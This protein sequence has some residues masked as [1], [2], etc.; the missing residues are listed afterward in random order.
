MPC[1][2]IFVEILVKYP[3]LKL[4]Q[5]GVKRYMAKT[6]TKAADNVF[7]KARMT[8]AKWNDRLSSR[9]GASEVTG[10]DRTRIAY[11]EL[12]TI[13]P[14]PEE[15]LILADCYNAPELC[16]HH[17]SRLCPIGRQTVEPLEVKELEAVTLQLLSAI[18]GLPKLTDDLVDIVEDGKIDDSEREGMESILKQLRK[19]ASRI[20]TLELV[21]EKCL[22][23]QREGEGG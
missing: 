6:A 14:Y 11:I 16:N 20:K 5:E 8:A 13:I 10:L 22:L 23:V 4:Y 17:C 1:S 3:L 2:Y 19:A 12:G 9:E 15:I 7:Y 18:R 21:Y